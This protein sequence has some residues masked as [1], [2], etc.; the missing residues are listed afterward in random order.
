M[1]VC[2]HA[3][4]LGSSNVALA[5]NDAGQKGL[6]ANIVMLCVSSNAACKQ[7]LTEWRNLLVTINTQGQPVVANFVDCETDKKTCQKYMPPG[8][9]TIYIET[10][11]GKR[12]VYNGP[13]TSGAI[14]MATMGLLN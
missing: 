8:Y 9:P 7:L 6:S 12:L 14:W 1:A 5:A 2:A 4:F 10:S 13:R 3:L 11:D